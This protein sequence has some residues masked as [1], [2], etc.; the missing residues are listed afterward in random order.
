MGFSSAAVAGL[1]GVNIS[2]F[3]VTATADSD[4]G[5][6]VTHG[7]TLPGGVAI[8]A[9][10]SILAIPVPILQVAAGLSLW[11]VTGKSATQITLSKSTATGSG[12]A[13][14]QLFL[15]VMLPHTIIQ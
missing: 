12:T 10:A 9:P 13:N 8:P 3:N 1:A 7:L 2:I 11:A 4:T 5:G 6:V 14:P 15:I